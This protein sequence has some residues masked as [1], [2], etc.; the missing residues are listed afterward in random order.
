MKSAL[1]RLREYRDSISPT[2]R[3]IADYLL[4][5]PGSLNCET[6]CIHPRQEGEDRSDNFPRL[7]VRVGEKAGGADLLLRLHDHPH[8]PADR[9]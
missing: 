7:P 3:T 9:L 8:V 6:V 5:A 1:L 2:E 4:D